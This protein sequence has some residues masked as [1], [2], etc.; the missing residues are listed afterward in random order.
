MQD[1]GRGHQESG[2]ERHFHNYQHVYVLQYTTYD[3]YVVLQSCHHILQLLEYKICSKLLRPTFGIGSI[4]VYTIVL[5]INSVLHCLNS[6]TEL[7]QLQEIYK[8][9]AEVLAA[10]FLV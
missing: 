2:G 9:A 3:S 7:F 4:G 8:C 6:S 10:N 5:I 1:S